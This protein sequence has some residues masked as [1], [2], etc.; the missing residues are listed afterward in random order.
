[1]KEFLFEQ[2]FQQLISPKFS[3]SKD[4]TFSLVDFLI[5]TPIKNIS[6][7][8]LR[9]VPK[10]SFCQDNIHHIQASFQQS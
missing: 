6:K 9:I 2:I 4:Y 3:K 8:E 5:I 10:S 1:M 7:N